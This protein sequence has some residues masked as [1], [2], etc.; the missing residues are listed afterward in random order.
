MLRWKWF[1]QVV[2]CCIKCYNIIIQEE[3]NNKE[4]EDILCLFTKN[5]QC[6]DLIGATNPVQKK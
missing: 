2:R 6:P 5:L 1:I 3:L 4:F